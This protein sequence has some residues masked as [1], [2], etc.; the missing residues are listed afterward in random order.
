M[1][2]S[3][4]EAAISPV[5]VLAESSPKITSLFTS[6]RD[7]LRAP[8]E[9]NGHDQITLGYVTNFN[10]SFVAH[11]NNPMDGRPYRMLVCPIIEEGDDHAVVVE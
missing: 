1:F 10:G 6:I 2:Q 9:Q 4:S 5:R 3:I 7:R 11:F 8:D